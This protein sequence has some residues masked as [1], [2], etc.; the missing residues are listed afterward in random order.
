MPALSSHA[1][2]K[3]LVKGDFVVSPILSKDQ[4]GKSSIDLRMG[5]VVM[6]ARAGLQS[7]VEPTAYLRTLDPSHHDSVKS[8][9][10]KHDRFDVPFQKSFLLHP[11]TLALVPT[12]EWV[13]LPNDVQGVVTARSSWAREGLNIATAT[14]VNPSYRGIIT[15]E[16][17]N[18][19]Q[20]PIMLYPGL[21]LAQIAFYQLDQKV[22]PDS[23][24][25][26]QFD[27]DFEPKAGDIAKHDQFFL[28]EKQEFRKPSTTETDIT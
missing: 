24:E 22:R 7:H 17:A 27:L 13:S 19:G 4:L 16:L 1:I 20:I 15:L 5:T 21:R 14:I 18:F 6:V 28:P 8:S 12:L 25:K 9:K 11:G 10:Q 2:S 26:P 23:D 3:R